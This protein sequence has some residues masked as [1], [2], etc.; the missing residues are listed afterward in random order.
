MYILSY[1]YG[2]GFTPLARFP[3]LQF[4]LP[5]VTTSILLLCLHGTGF[6]YELALVLNSTA[7]VPKLRYLEEELVQEFSTPQPSHQSANK[8]QSLMHRIT[9]RD[10]FNYL[11]LDP[12]GLKESSSHREGSSSVDLAEFRKFMESV[13]YV[14]KGKNSRP[15][16]HLRDAKSCLTNEL[17]KVRNVHEI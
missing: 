17:T 3:R 8:T 11:L 15:V 1:A 7:P 4:Y 13:F 10:N 9:V 12:R 14:G 6:K 5:R 2:L 16:Q